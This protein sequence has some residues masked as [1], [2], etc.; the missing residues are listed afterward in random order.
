MTQHEIKGFMKWLIALVIGATLGII[1]FIYG[2]VA[3][4][5]RSGNN[6]LISQQVNQNY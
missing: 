4:D 5:T 3:R 1:F 6:N 2:W